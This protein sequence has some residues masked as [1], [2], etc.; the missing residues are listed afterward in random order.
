MPF[1]DKFK[2]LFRSNG[3]HAECRQSSAYQHIRR[4]VDPRTVW[5]IVGE[6]G[7]G[8][9]GKVQRAQHVSS[10]LQSA[11]K[12][13]E[14]RT[15]EEIEDYLIEIEILTQCRHKNVVGLYEV[16]FY[17]QCLWL[18]LE[19]CSGGAVDSIMV[20]LEKPL[21]ESQIR[22]IC[23]E[24]CEGLQFLHNCFVIHR[25]LKAG[26]VLLTSEGGVKL[27]DFGV[28]AKNKDAMQR[29]DSFIG[30]PYW[31]A[32]E[33]MMCE[34][35]KEQPYS[36]KCDI[37]SLGITLIEFAEMDPPYHEMSPMRVLIKIQKSEPPGLAQPK[38]WSGEFHNFLSRCLVKSQSERASADELL[39]HSFIKNHND[40]KPVLQLLH[41]LKADVI[42]EEVEEIVEEEASEKKMQY[43]FWL[44]F[45]TQSGHSMESVGSTPQRSLTPDSSGESLHI[46][47]RAMAIVENSGSSKI[48]A[49]QDA[50]KPNKPTE[51]GSDNLHTKTAIEAAEN[52]SNVQEANEILDDLYASL[53]NEELKR[54]SDIVFQGDNN[55]DEQQQPVVPYKEKA[56]DVIGEEIISNDN[57]KLTKSASSI[58]RVE[59]RPAVN[60]EYVAGQSMNDDVKAETKRSQR[61]VKQN[62]E[63]S[64]HVDESVI[65][66]DHCR[67]KMDASSAQRRCRL[68]HETRS[69]DRV[70]SFGLVEH[71]EPSCKDE[72]I[73]DHSTADEKRKHYFTSSPRG[74]S[75]EEEGQF[76]SCSA[77]AGVEQTGFAGSGRTTTSGDNA[78]PS[79]EK[80][81]DRAISADGV[82]N[83]TVGIRSTRLTSKGTAD[84][85]CPIFEQA[86][87]TD[88]TV[89]DNKAWPRLASAAWA[90]C[91]EPPPEPPVDYDNVSPLNSGSG[92]Q[93]LSTSS[94]SSIEAS[95]QSVLR[96]AASALPAA[97]TAA[98]ANDDDHSYGSTVPG[99]SVHSPKF[100]N[101]A[102]QSGGGSGSFS[103][104]GGAFNHHHHHHSSDHSVQSDTLVARKSSDQ[105][106]PVAKTEVGELTAAANGGSAVMMRRNAHRRTVTKKTRVFVV[107]GIQVTSTTYHVMADE[108]ANL[109]KV[110][111]DFRLRKVELQELRRLQKEE[112]RQFQELETRGNVAREQQARKSEQDTQTLL[113]QYENDIEN[114]TRYQKKQ[115]EDAERVQEEDTKMAMKRLKLEEEREV[116]L[117]RESLRQ[118]HRLLK[119]E[120][121]ILPKADRKEIYKQRK[122]FLELQQLEREKQFMDRI[123]TTNALTLNR[124]EDSHRQ[125]IALLERQFLQQ[126]HHLLRAREAALWDLE[127]RQLH[128]KHQLAKNQ[129]K[130]VFFLQRS[131]MLMRH[132]KELE[133]VKKLN[134]RKEDDMIR[135]QA[136][137][138]KRL[139]KILRSETKTR[140]LMFRESL[141]IRMLNSPEIAA[142]LRE[143]EERERM[144]MSQELKKQELKHRKRLEL[145]KAENETTLKE[146]E[147]LQNEKRKMLLEHEN[148]RLKHFDEEYANEIKNW[149]CN[150][151]PR[152]QKLEEKF[153]IELAEQEQFYQN[154]VPASPL[155]SSNYVSASLFSGSNAMP[156]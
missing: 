29:R 74:G 92:S 68:A 98:S 100:E 53:T 42:A 59:V 113:R 85:F 138:R 33:V 78:S 14:T 57:Q 47:R 36:C 88:V 45:D 4:D 151:K 49:S 11:A 86:A 149:K 22:Y 83:L 126:K 13:I 46:D 71:A 23:H 133:H 146:L 111:E 128:E 67:L 137:E 50:A 132:Q 134:Q 8:A 7:D 91:D 58:L 104:S 24:I 105:L 116:K 56:V 25:D 44:S 30:T 34:T 110:K 89:V 41:E 120:V 122:E 63:G 117:F 43:P 27:A 28:S 15:E 147:Q 37:W 76:F 140:T 90:A 82:Q 119:Q 125:K 10:K 1:F 154:S 2:N 94:S 124:L 95:S 123:Q 21:N 51:R 77:F 109:Y 97:T 144:R 129:M 79:A 148:L 81:S 39:Q 115:L 114:L 152:K 80:K 135:A 48:I 17:E 96:L 16:Y 155:L 75:G 156:Y 150:L 143:F 72:G 108:D 40:P 93:L 38:K 65:K 60:D 31:M 61:F 5:E 66:S 106:Q 26:N 142:K 18:M 103:D 141:K 73:F 62:S 127:E 139:P 64:R 6:L 131:Q 9:F 20:E 102:S 87:A 32:P 130:E 19:F 118:E 35:F 12:V 99:T 121:D 54:G 84:A 3:Y 145:L 55:T 112:V 70:G 69:L 136:A 52:S 101:S 153:S 107:D